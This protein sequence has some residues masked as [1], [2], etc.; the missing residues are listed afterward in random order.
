MNQ[1]FEKIPKNL[2]IKWDT[3]KN[4]ISVLVCCLAFGA[5]GQMDKEGDGYDDC[6]SG[7]CYNGYGKEEINPGLIYN[8]RFVDGRP[9]GQG[10]MTYPC[11]HTFEGEWH[12]GKRRKGTLTFSKNTKIGKR[13][14]KYVGGF[15]CFSGRDSFHG[16]G[17]LYLTDGTKNWGGKYEKWRDGVPTSGEFRITNPVDYCYLSSLLDSGYSQCSSVEHCE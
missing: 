9:H 12:E 8:G 17:T 11:G 2:L 3:S 13:F 5:F 14:E 15:N 10:K 4:I 7:D 1:I 6:L 16:I